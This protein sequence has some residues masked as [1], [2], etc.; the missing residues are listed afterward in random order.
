MASA[1]AIRLTRR[2]HAHTP[3]LLFV[4]TT[5]L[6]LL[7]ALNSG[8]NLLYWIFGLA[9]G[10]VIV[11]GFLSGSSLMGLR[12]VGLPPESA[13]AGGNAV[14]RYRLTN[15]NRWMPAVGLSLEDLSK[16]PEAPA[17][18]GWVASIPAGQSIIIELHAPA[19][20]RGRFKYPG[21]RALTTFPFGLT[22]KS[23]R[24]HQPRTLLV[25]PKSAPIRSSV[26]VGSLGGGPRMRR[27]N[28]HLGLRGEPYG[29]R[30]YTPGDP[31][32]SIAWKP[33]ARTDELRVIEESLPS[34]AL[35]RVAFHLESTASDALADGAVELAAG[36]CLAAARQGIPVE[37]EGIE[38][39]AAPTRRGPALPLGLERTLD[40]LSWFDPRGLSPSEDSSRRG[41]VVISDAMSTGRSDVV[42]Q[43]QAWLDQQE[44]TP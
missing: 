21:L 27:T 7:G 29:L 13:T 10:G 9:I 44:A 41:T 33:S 34:R 40:A 15:T 36:V 32:R 28:A 20:R 11:S 17:L 26:L 6:V 24:A 3:G 39:D 1:G 19:Q 37:I 35:F 43:V 30:E 12:I 8:N 22:R 5:V 42:L 16:S 2:Y 14:F 25:R 23:V 4:G 18:R 31:F 38:D